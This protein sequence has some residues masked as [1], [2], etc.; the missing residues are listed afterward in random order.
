MNP[1]KKYICTNKRCL[2]EFTCEPHF[3]FDCP[4]C[5]SKI[6]EFKERKRGYLILDYI[7]RYG[8]RETWLIIEKFPTPAERIELRN[9]FFE[10][11]KQRGQSFEP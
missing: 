2:H 6:E 1:K 9:I 4:L 3:A 10:V 5:G 11:L 8:A 7:Q